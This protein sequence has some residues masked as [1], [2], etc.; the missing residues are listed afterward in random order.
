MK[1]LRF[2]AALLL[3]ALPFIVFA[4]TVTQNTQSTRGVQQGQLT[5]GLGYADSTMQVPGVDP[6]LHA[7]YVAEQALAR[8]D[9]HLF[10][11]ISNSA[12]ANAAAD[13]SGVMDVHRYR[14]LKLLVKAYLTN[15]A[16]NATAR[17][18]FQLREHMNSNVDTMS[19]FAE[20]PY[21]ANSQSVVVGLIDTTITG[22][23]Q[24]GSA[25]TA[26]SGEFT[27]YVAG[28]RASPLNAVA[29]VVFSYPNGMSIPVDNIMGRAT[30]F[31]QLSIRVRNLGTA[32]CVV[33]V[34]V[35]G[36]AE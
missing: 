20:Y 3:L 25:S 2:G 16:S 1:G 35:L 36:F 28:N 10:T 14:Y 6:T 11:A 12:L 9:V 30:R 31:N 18:A 17:L 8:D 13:S 7:W 33:Y 24:T 4:Q 21:G 27:V 26:W 23:T 32:A 22:Q 29:A 19:T 5:G 34:Y 15:G